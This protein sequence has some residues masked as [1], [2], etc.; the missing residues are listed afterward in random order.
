LHAAKVN[1]AEHA[2]IVLRLFIFSPYK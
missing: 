2:N 1:S